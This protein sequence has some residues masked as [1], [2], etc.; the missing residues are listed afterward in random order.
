VGNI[1]GNIPSLSR[2]VRLPSHF[3]SRT[4]PVSERRIRQSVEREAPLQPDTG[5]SVAVRQYARSTRC[6]LSRSRVPDVRRL[7]HN[8]LRRLGDAGKMI[9]K[10]VT[11]RGRTMVGL[12][13]VDEVIQMDRRVLIDGVVAVIEA[14]SRNV[15]ATGS[16]APA[17]Q[18]ALTR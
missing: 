13:L 3:T 8:G 2:D 12:P 7:S 11:G 14:V 18:P 9:L 17:K 5:R 1:L 4:W 15:R 16:A 10:A 6:C